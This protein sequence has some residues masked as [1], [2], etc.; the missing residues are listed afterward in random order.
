MTSFHQRFLGKIFQCGKYRDMSSQYL[1]CLDFLVSSVQF[2]VNSGQ[3][4]P[5]SFALQA[6]F[7]GRFPIRPVTRSSS[8]CGSILGQVRKMV[9]LSRLELLT[10]RLSG[11]RSN[12]LSYRPIIDANAILLCIAV[13]HRQTLRST[14]LSVRLP[15]VFLVPCYTQNFRFAWYN[16]FK[17]MVETRRIELLTP[18]LQGRCSPS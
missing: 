14:Y 9:G 17:K 2:S 3:R 6:R 16:L 15:C 12:Q 7:L 18:C 13:S 5:I 10:S 4:L 8:P 1:P 11:V